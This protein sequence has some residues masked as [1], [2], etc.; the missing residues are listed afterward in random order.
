MREIFVIIYLFILG[1]VQYKGWLPRNQE[2]FFNTFAQVNYS[3]KHSEIE[4]D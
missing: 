3:S 1:I 4:D 2:T